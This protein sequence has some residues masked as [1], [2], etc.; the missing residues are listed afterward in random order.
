LPGVSGAGGT[1]SGGG[2]MSVRLGGSVGELGVG[3]GMRGVETGPVKRIPVGVGV[4]FAPPD[5][6]CVDA[7]ARE[8]ERTSPSTAKARIAK[9]TATAA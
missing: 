5:R 6:S 7:P 8:E 1:L 3:G 2:W 4:T 9:K